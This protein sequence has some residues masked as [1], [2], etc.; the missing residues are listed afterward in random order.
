VKGL[1]WL[2]TRPALA[3]FGAVA[4]AVFGVV[5]AGR[6]PSGIYPEVEFP[7]IV[8]VARSGDAPPD[9]TQIAL[10]RPLE[11]ELATV[12]G[13]ERIRS[14]TI[15]GAAELS[16]QFAPGTDMWRAL[17]LVES[18]V[19][20]ARSALPAAADVTVERLTTTSFPV[21][22]YNL[23][24]DVDPRRLRELAEFVLR[25]AFS[26]VRGVGRVEVL[27]GAVREVEIV[28][29][30]EQV[31]ALHA[32]PTQI[33]AAV[34]SQDVLQAVGRLE[35]AHSAVTVMASGEPSDLDDLRRVPVALGPDGTPVLLGSVADVTEGAEDRLVRVSGPGGETVLLSVSRLPGASTPDVVGAVQAVARDMQKSLPSGVRLT[36]VYDQATLVD[37]SV[38]SVRDAILLGMALSIVVLALFL[39][40]LRAG[41]VAALTVPVT[42]G[43]TFVP[44]A[45]LGHGLNL[46]SL[47]G[48]AVAIGLVIDDAIVVVEAISRRVQAGEAPK[49]AAVA[50]TH[51]LFAALLGTTTT[52]IV[53][54]LPLAWLEGVVGRFFSALATTLSVAVALSFVFAVTVVPLAAAVWFVPHRA[55]TDTSP[56]SVAFRRHARSFVG[57]R[58]LGF[59]LAAGLVLSGGYGATHLETGFLPTFDEGAF[60]LDYFLPAGTS[61]TDTDAAARKLEKVL[62]ATPE[63][64]TYSRRTGAE[65]GPAAATQLNRGDIMVQLRP[66]AE[67]GRSAEDVIAD[68]RKR[69]ERDVPEARTE[70]V[71]VLQDVLN[72]LA[73]TPRPI[74]LKLFGDDYS[75][76]RR[77]AREVVQRIQGIEGLVDVYPGV[78]DPAPELRFRIDGTA[79][80]RAGRTASD[81]S[82]EL[83]SALHG[84]FASVLRRPDRP[85]NV[86][87]RYP[88]DVRFD[89]ARVT[90]LPLVVGAGVTRISSVARPE[91]RATES[92][93]V[94]ESLRPAVIITADHE[95]RDL[96]SVAADVRQ[97]L[98]GL[99]L[100]AGYRLEIG[101]QYEGQRDTQANLVRVLGLA[102]VAVLV[103]LL[104]Q[105]RRA[106]L[107]VVVI[108]AVPLAL[109]GALST[110][111]VTG[112]PLNAS[113]LMGCVLLVGL[114]VKNGILLLEQYERLLD[115]GTPI[116]AAL[117]QAVQRRLRPILMT[118]LATLAGLLPLA[119]GVGSGAEIQ[120]PLAVAVIGGLLAST[121]VTLVIVPAIVR[122][123]ARREPAPNRI[124]SS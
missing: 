84:V 23:T 65:L 99:S 53:V 39:R 55:S 113:S 73:G 32:G 83:D 90:E 37:E 94:R 107:A 50:G 106:L 6:L 96:G 105:F 14:K 81:L 100:P 45:W 59:L 7:R 25:P 8:V 124:R 58:W 119:L 36:P 29:R 28:L 103:V 77:L 43:A 48:L 115:Q 79:A 54:F 101:G 91:Q 47:G 40:D 71:Q 117:V 75:V 92:L 63:V 72:D 93:L 120:R 15:R 17:Q 49:E 76:L 9:A 57:N 4:L 20:E 66:R 61:L 122:V 78:E 95:G 46:M 30:P 85:L 16:L 114:V 1:A 87:V 89:P 116:D 112:L 34:R 31:A 123:T 86:R 21:L 52:T 19:A 109:M 5:L 10:T 74:E 97:K 111:S 35:R 110:L 80:A 11:A 2:S 104:A 121:A 33:A 62:T 26:R 64:A 3:W 98:A 51:D 102:L 69:S 24:G 108:V 38:R 88:D 68:V 60:V 118:T 22:T 27:G 70:F 42:L 13:I 18:R 67:R 12:L 56:L 44:L 82:T 41:V